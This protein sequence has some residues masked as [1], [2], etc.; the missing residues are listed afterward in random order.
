MKPHGIVIAAL[1]LMALSGCFMSQVPRVE[2]GTLFAPGDVAF[3]SPDE[4]TCQIGFPSGDGY[5]IAPENGEEEEVRLRFEPLT[6]ANRTPVYLGEVELREGD[7]AIWTYIVA[8]P[9]GGFVNE[10]P[11]FDIIMPG[12]NDTAPGRDAEFGIVR[13]DAYTCLVTDLEA[14]RTFL[15][16]NYSAQFASDAWWAGQ[17]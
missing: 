17:D 9:S 15:T 13:A 10:A 14:F 5:L 3:C 11:R 12:C 16:A 8:R 2:T 7:E 1:S 6:E 4:E